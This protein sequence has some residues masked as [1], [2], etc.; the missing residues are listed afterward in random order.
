MLK[1]KECTFL[2]LI[3]MLMKYAKKNKQSKQTDM[4]S[5]LKNDILSFYVMGHDYRKDPGIC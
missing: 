5:I 4:I 3:P 1:P 2:N